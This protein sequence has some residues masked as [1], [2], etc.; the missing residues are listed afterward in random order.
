MNNVALEFS[1][2]HSLNQLLQFIPFYVILESHL[3]CFLSNFN[4]EVEVR[5]VPN[6]KGILEWYLLDSFIRFKIYR[7]ETGSALVT[8]KNICMFCQHLRHLLYFGVQI[9][10]FY[11]R[12]FRSS[13]KFQFLSSCWI[14]ALCFHQINIDWD[15]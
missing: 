12:R 2:D 1:G 14:F 9:S 3:Y 11:V 15:F 7:P 8:T 5:L 4:M 6:L 10:E 13:F